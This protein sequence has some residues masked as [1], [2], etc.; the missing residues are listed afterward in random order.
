[1]CQIQRLVTTLVLCLLCAG[2]RSTGAEEGA[3]ATLRPLLEKWVE[4]RQLISRERQR[5]RQEDE[6]LQARL[7]VL[8]MRE[9][10]LRERTAEVQKD[11]TQ[12]EEKRATLEAESA[13]LDESLARLEASV[14][15]LEQQTLA[16][17]QAAPEPLRKKVEVLSQQFPKDA[18][19]SGMSLSLRYQNLIGVLNTM[20]GFN[21]EITL[22]TEVRQ[23]GEGPANEV[24]VLYF[25]LGQAYFCNRDASLAG[26]GRPS[27]DGWTWERRDAIG[28]V[29]AALIA[30]NLNEKTPAYE[31]LPVKLAHSGDQT[32]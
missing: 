17:L 14:E 27:R 6:L 18:G 19:A 12:A 24:R 15:T 7:H 3:M 10:D 9:K 8:T 29:V 31:A 25:G 21:N 20:N 5:A 30:Q 28:P 11:L 23:F 2:A 4:T 22:T 16:L 13:H 26:V 32:P 1:M